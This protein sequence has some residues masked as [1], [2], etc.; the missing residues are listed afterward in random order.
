MPG[1]LCPRAHRAPGRPRC[2]QTMATALCPGTGSPAANLEAAGP[3]RVE[4][5]EVSPWLP[6]GMCGQEQRRQGQTPAITRFDKRPADGCTAA[7][8][9]ERS[10]P[11]RGGYGLLKS[12][13]RLK[14]HHWK[15]GSPASAD[16]RA[17]PRPGVPVCR[18]LW[19][20]HRDVCFVQQERRGACPLPRGSLSS[21]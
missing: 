3:C 20:Q 7:Y 13:Q 14:S 1:A 5:V 10:G 15:R 16:V 19:E 8:V 12:A 18:P 9:P 21:S 4:W 6:P 2:T 17:G 11:S